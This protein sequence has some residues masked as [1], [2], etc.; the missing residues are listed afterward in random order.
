MIKPNTIL[1]S[2]F[3]KIEAGESPVHS[4]HSLSQPNSDQDELGSN[5]WDFTDEEHPLSEKD[6]ESSTFNHLSED[7]FD[8]ANKLQ[9]KIAR[10]EK[11]QDKVQQYHERFDIPS[12]SMTID[13]DKTEGYKQHGLNEV[14]NENL[15]WR[16]VN[17]DFPFSIPGVKEF[18]V[19]DGIQVEKLKNETNPM[20]FFNEFLH[21][22]FYDEVARM[23][24][25][26][27]RM[28]GKRREIIEEITPKEIKTFFGILFL[29]GLMKKPNIPSYWSNDSLISTECL[30]RVMSYQRFQKIKKYITF[31]D[32]SKPRPNNGDSFY[33]VR[34]FQDHVLENSKRVYIPERDL[35]IDESIILYTGLHRL[36]VYMPQKPNRYGF[37]A[38]VLAE[39]STGYIC[40]F[41]MSEGRLKGSEV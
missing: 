26:A 23:S 9:E 3:I 1:P 30:S 38:F 22:N 28:D 10:E 25:I 2:S 14:F 5:M 41:M 31:Y 4:Q 11:I 17:Y 20:E 24:N 12:L 13:K 15:E 37:K 35:S 21:E 34:M 6:S 33:K 29:F 32:K 39:A 27:I 36:K 16:K 18:D 19:K 40:N 8:L 7:E